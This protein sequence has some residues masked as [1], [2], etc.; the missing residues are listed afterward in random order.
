MKRRISFLTVVL[1]FIS[2]TYAQS[3]FKDYKAGHTF[4][5]SLPDYMS[6]TIGLNDAASFQFKN[7][8]KDIAGFIIFD[9]KEELELVNMKYSSIS[10]FYEGFIKDFLIKEKK[11]SVSQP[12]S[13]TIGEVEFI[14][15]DLTYYDKESKS[16]IYYFI[17]IVETKTAYYK[18]LCLG[19]MDSKD[20]YKADFQRILY[21]IK[22]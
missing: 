20:K 3:T 14:E 5:I 13:K 8:V 22:D 4:N 11:R 9:T 16:E 12:T 18:V 2:S 6:K 15:S 10:E 17:G 7:T 19:G 1:I 21:S